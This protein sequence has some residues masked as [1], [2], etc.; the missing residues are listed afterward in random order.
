MEKNNLLVTKNGMI[1]NC[2]TKVRYDSFIKSGWKPYTPKSATPPPKEDKG[3]KNNPEDKGD[4][5]SSK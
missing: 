2:H 1:H 3:D 4:N 5:T